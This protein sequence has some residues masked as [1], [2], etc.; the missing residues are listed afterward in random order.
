MNSFQSN[1]LLARVF[2]ENCDMKVR[3]TEISI[4]RDI[5]ILLARE[6]ELSV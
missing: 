4:R 1:S 2:K 6:H 5:S 3:P